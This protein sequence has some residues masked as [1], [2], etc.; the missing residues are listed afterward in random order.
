MLRCINILQSNAKFRYTSKNQ[1][2]EQKNLSMELNAETWWL[3]SVE[4]FYGGLFYKF[5]CKLEFSFL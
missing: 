5:I 1:N 3:I 4:A 2:Y